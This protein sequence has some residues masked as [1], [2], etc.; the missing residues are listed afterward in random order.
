MS[1]TQTCPE[2]QPLTDGYLQKMDAYWRAANYLAA[3]QLY[4][5]DLPDVDTGCLR[6]LLWRE[7]RRQP[8]P[9]QFGDR[10][11]MAV[12]PVVDEGAE[13]TVPVLPLAVPVLPPHSVSP[14]PRSSRIASSCAC[15]SCS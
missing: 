9:L 8:G 7:A 15:S 13:G 14:S 12:P 2:K 10:S 3:A 6:E 1:K 4:L 11:V 5:L